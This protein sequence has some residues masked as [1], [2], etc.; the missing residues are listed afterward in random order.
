MARGAPDRFLN[1]ELWS[2]Y[3]Q[4]YVINHLLSQDPTPTS[5]TLRSKGWEFSRRHR[6]NDGK[7]YT[8][9]FALQ[10]NRK[11]ANSHDQRESYQ[12]YR[13]EYYQPLS[14]DGTSVS[15]NI[16]GRRLCKTI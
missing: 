16:N 14:R 6:N 1:I 12:P 2:E 9:D 11:L 5:V 3:D 15:S 13:I 7:L 10:P 8:K 4:Q